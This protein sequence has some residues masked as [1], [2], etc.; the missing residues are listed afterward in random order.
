MKIKGLKSIVV[1]GKN[2]LK[3]W[4]FSVQLGSS[5]TNYFKDIGIQKNKSEELK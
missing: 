3:C 5:S 2:L 1:A 4:T